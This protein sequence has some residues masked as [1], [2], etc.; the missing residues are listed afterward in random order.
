MQWRFVMHQLPNDDASSTINPIKRFCTAA[1]SV[2]FKAI[3]VK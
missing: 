3:T 1:S 2:A